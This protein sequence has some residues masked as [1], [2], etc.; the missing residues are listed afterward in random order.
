MDIASI[1]VS[2]FVLL[3]AITVHE[4]SHGWAA[5]KM[6]D[7]TAHAMG[8]ITLNPIAHT[9][10]T[11]STNRTGFF[12]IHLPLHRNSLNKSHQ[13]TNSHSLFRK[14]PFKQ[15]ASIFLIRQIPSE[16]PPLITIAN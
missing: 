10:A 16:I 8:R 11:A 5:Y 12:I 7:P 13:T 15:A 1:I 4:A 2:L 14:A 9:A 3:F 6:G